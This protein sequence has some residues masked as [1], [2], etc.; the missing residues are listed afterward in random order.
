M[1]DGAAAG[2]SAG[3]FEAAVGGLRRRMVGEIVRPDDPSYGAARRVFNAA[4]DRYPALIAR[5]QDVAD[6]IQAVNFAH[7]HGLPLAVRSGGHGIGGHG[8]GDGALV[9]DLSP[10]KE[11]ALDPARRVA[12][13]Q[14]GL[15]WGEYAAQAHRHALATPAGDT[16]AVGVGGLTLGGGIGGLARRYGLTI[17]S[18]LSADVVTA[19]GRLLTASADEHP[20]LF[21]ALRGG[22]GNFGIAT[23]F[24]FRLHPVGTILGGA[25][26]YPATAGVIQ[27]Y[28]AGAAAAPDELTTAG[29]VMRAPP[30][31]F[32]P[33]ERHGSLV[34]LLTACYAGDVEDGRRTLAP[35][36]TLATP[37]A[38]AICPMPYPSLF[39]LT[40]AGAAPGLVHHV[41][42]AYLETIDAAL[43]ETVLEHSR[44]MTSPLGMVQIRVLGGAVARVPQEATAFA[45]RQKPFMLTILNRFA[46]G[47]AGAVMGLDADADADVD[48]HLAWTERFWG[49][50]R[51]YAGGVNANF[52]GDEGDARVREA[53]PDATY[54][55]LAR[56]KRRYDPANTFR[57]NQNIRP[58]QPEPSTDETASAN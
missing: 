17:D 6:V 32:I 39:D 55:R 16:A 54:E 30:L 47:A 36:R 42:S 43:A 46:P 24:E 15:T 35:L 56:I 10:M 57:L 1:A 11:L 21:W 28:A 8:T 52:L 48:R 14:P 9:V 5:C 26:V 3:S 23:G 50:V 19:D 20:D 31:P 45:H 12:R 4:Y 53:Y 18:L 44:R 29:A 13:V 40:A 49:D 34:F 51:P 27:G 2:P 41:R 37:V 25:V 33:P 22:G 38:D 58:A 7:E